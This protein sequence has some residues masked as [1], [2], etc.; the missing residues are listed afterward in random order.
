[1]GKTVDRC[2][3]GY[4]PFIDAFYTLVG[5]DI[6]NKKNYKSAIAV[7][8]VMLFE[9]P[10]FSEVCERNLELLK[11]KKEALV[12]EAGKDLINNWDGTCDKFFGKNCDMTV[13]LND[14]TKDPVKKV[15]KSVRILCR[16]KWDAWLQEKNK[17]APKPPKWRPPNK[18]LT[19]GASSS[20]K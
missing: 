3:V 16:T 11:A 1:M 6:R 7:L 9:A 2:K 15:A 19:E 13:T 5:H 14:D 4:N 17:D 10:R 12:G 18:K 8:L 20:R